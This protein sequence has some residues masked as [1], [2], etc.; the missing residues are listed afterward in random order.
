[1]DQ[2]LTTIIPGESV[3]TGMRITHHSLKSVFTEHHG[4][5]HHYSRTS[6]LLNEGGMLWRFG[7]AKKRG[8]RAPGRVGYIR[9]LVVTPNAIP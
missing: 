3:L 7:A 2:I 1:M 8:E 9:S 4:F 5:K 6:H